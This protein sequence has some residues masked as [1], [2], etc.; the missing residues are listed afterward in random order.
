MG[1]QFIVASYSTVVWP[2]VTRFV[3]VRLQLPQPFSI[4]NDSMIKNGM[5]ECNGFKSQPNGVSLPCKPDITK[6]N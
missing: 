4:S 6:W 2:A 3:L 1:D 5:V